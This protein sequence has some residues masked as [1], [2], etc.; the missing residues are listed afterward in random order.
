[1]KI[2]ELQKEI[3]ANAVAKGFWDKTPNIGELLMLVTSELGEA[4]E[5]DRKGK[6]ASALDIAWME[7]ST[8]KSHLLM[9]HFPDTIKDTFQD[10][11]ADAVIRLLDLAEGFTIDLEFHIKAKME[12]NATRKR[13][14]GKKY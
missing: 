9:E 8:D 11:I 6:W 13:L 2:A 10:E 3:H 12:Y 1:M 5:A 14:H 7:S 4:L